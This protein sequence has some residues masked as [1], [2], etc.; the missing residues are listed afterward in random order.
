MSF[1]TLEKR[2]QD[3]KQQT[4]EEK[5]IARYKKL[6]EKIKKENPWKEID[7][8]L[9]MQPEPYA[10]PRKSRKL[11]AMGKTN[12]FYNPREKYKRKL[13]KEIEKKLEELDPNFQL[14]N[15]EVILKIEVGLVSPK[16]YTDSKTKWKLV[17]DRIINPMVRPD[18]DNWAKPIMDV[19]NKLVYE[20][21]GQ[22]T[23]L[24]ATKVYSNLD[25]P[26]IH[27]WLRYRDKPITL[28]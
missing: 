10:R 5:E 2:K 24:I 26:Y 18:I 4:K 21:D 17:L 13:H 11:E 12:P 15:G 16:K 22:I 23:T 8:I 20:D 6:C 19:L 14:I 3:T 27:V 7:F 25:H 28:R 1:Y 9:D